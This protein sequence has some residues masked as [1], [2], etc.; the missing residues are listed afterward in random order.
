MR[1]SQCTRCDQLIE[2][3]EPYEGDEVLCPACDNITRLKEI[4]PSELPEPED[5]ESD[6][7][8]SDGSRKTRAPLRIQ[9]ADALP[10]PDQ[11]PV[12][13]VKPT[14][15]DGLR[16]D[17]P[18]AEEVSIEA[19]DLPHNSETSSVNPEL[20]ILAGTD[21][22]KVLLQWEDSSPKPSDIL[23][24]KGYR[25]RLPFGRKTLITAAILLL[26]MG[27]VS[28]VLRPSEAD[29][30]RDAQNE[31]NE[32]MAAIEHAPVVS[33]PT[34]RSQTLA[35]ATDRPT[36]SG[37]A[38]GSGRDS[39]PPTN[40]GRGMVQVSA[41]GAGKSGTPNV[42]EM[43]FPD[44]PTKITPNTTRSQDEAYAFFAGLAMELPYRLFDNTVMDLRGYSFAMR[45]GMTEFEN[46][47]RL[48]GGTVAEKNDDGLYLRI[49]PRYFGNRRIVFIK[50]LPAVNG[51]AANNSF[52][53][54][55]RLNGV[56][57]YN[58]NGG[59]EVAIE[60]YDFGHLPSD[61]MIDL[62]KDEAAKREAQI[63]QAMVTKALDKEKK[64]TA[65]EVQKKAERDAR[66]VAFLLK[67]VKDGSASAQYSLGL[68]HLDGD[69]VDKNRREGIRLLKAS[70]K[71]GYAR[72]KKKI[73]DDNL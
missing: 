53:V 69:G 52:G 63:R 68:R 16:G 72:A 65:K 13:P 7:A 14:N 19:T 56:H 49:D 48:L 30:Q 32:R 37:F 42:I 8:K 39:P 71:Q 35:I 21:A 46:G 33:T 11:D 64:Q 36:G 23:T 25:L 44:P 41:P 20:K 60:K 47:W 67:R 57:K 17:A 38:F 50:G 40:T 4:P 55:G 58:P 28:Y 51:L 18:A 1:I 5:H 61:K 73:A 22:A 9:S 34:P 27:V 6:D 59:A 15:E 2:Y 26:I 29:R 45:Q 43:N 24:P 12:A 10:K 31:L 70:A 3:D 54:I 66:V 62:V